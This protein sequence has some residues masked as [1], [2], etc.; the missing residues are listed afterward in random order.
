[1]KIRK[2]YANIYK[3]VRP[4]AGIFTNGVETQLV[5]FHLCSEAVTKVERG[6]RRRRREETEVSAAIRRSVEIKMVSAVRLF[7]AL[8]DAVLMLGGSGVLWRPADPSDAT[9]IGLL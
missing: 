6:S 8:S 5:D 2:I 3:N 4:T 1:M 9:L 7:P